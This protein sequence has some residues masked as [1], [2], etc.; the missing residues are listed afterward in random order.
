[1]GSEA[2]I[3]W[4]HPEK[5]P[6]APDVFIHL[7]ERCGLILD[8]DRWVMNKVMH[9]QSVWLSA[10]LDA[11]PVAIN[12]SGRGF[13]DS[14]LAWSLGALADSAGVPPKLIEIEITERVLA[15][16]ADAARSTVS[17]L[18]SLGFGVAI[19]DFG[20]GYSSLSY[21]KNFSVSVLKIDRSFVKDICEVAEDRAICNAIIAMA[22][23]L[24]VRSVAEGVETEAQR[25]M[26]REQGCDYAQGY[27]FHKPLSVTDF[28]ALLRPL[29][30]QSASEEPAPPGNVEALHRRQQPKPAV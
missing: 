17:K 7:A 27:L 12:L 21:L 11:L 19:D 3:R 25:E 28:Q 26:L 6:V 2:L 20:T 24:D 15:N 23:G 5:G 22:K 4:H 29:R 9:Q 18:R 16:D 14:G 1:M 13:V 30:P 10:G 8:I